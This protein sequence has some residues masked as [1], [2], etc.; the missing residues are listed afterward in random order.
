MISAD[1]ARKLSQEYEEISIRKADLWWDTNG[2]SQ[3]ETMVKRD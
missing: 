1:V 3:I 2:N